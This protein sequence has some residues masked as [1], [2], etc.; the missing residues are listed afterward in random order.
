MD[1]GAEAEVAD[2]GVEER[3]GD[4]RGP[5]DAVDADV[6]RRLVQPRWDGDAEGKVEDDDGL[7][8]SNLLLE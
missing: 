3:G 5:E 2:G 8:E 4:R 1:G 6:W 7:K